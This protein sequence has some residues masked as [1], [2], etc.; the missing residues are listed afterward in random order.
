MAR[1]YATAAAYEEYTGQAPPDDIDAVLARASR[2]LENTVFRLCWYKADGDGMPSDV[3]VAAA[4]SNAV[5]AQVEWWDETGDE[6]GVAGMWGS[7]KL[8]SASMSTG[9]SSSGSAGSAGGR[10]VADAALEALRGPDMTP[11]RF[12]LGMVCS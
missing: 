10:T 8:G 5:C 2:F 11:D 4:F 1:V 7:V 12:V 9:S 3:V 6:L